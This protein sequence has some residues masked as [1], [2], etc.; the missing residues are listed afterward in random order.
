MVGVGTA[1]IPMSNDGKSFF[2][3]LGDSEESWGFNY[4][5]TIYHKGVNF[6]N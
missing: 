4:D 6:L 3:F 1:N 5:G 2:N